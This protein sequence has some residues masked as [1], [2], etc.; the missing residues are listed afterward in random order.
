MDNISTAGMSNLTVN[1]NQRMA[2]IHVRLLHRIHNVEKSHNDVPKRA[3]EL[4]VRL[5]FAGK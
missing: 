2:L 3:G 1:V 4:S 5:Q